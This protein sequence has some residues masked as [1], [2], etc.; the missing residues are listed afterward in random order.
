MSSRIV[1]GS[2]PIINN[3][4]WDAALKHY[5]YNSK[6]LVFNSTTYITE[7]INWD[8]KIKFRNSE[9]RLLSYLFRIEAG[10]KAT[11]SFVWHVFQFDIFVISFDGFLIGR[12][13]VLWRAQSFIFRVLKKK[14]IAMPYGG[15]CYVYENVKS[16]DI[17]QGLIDSYPMT[18]KEQKIIARRVSYWK[19]HANIILPGF[20]YA[21][22]YNAE[23][24]HGFNNIKI[25]PSILAIDIDSWRSKRPPLVKGAVVEIA[26]MPN[27]RGLKG[28]E[29]IIEV[30]EELKTEG[31]KINFNLIEKR[32]NSEVRILMQDKIHILIDQ[33]YA[34]GYGLNAIE[35]MASSCVVMA[36]LS[37][38]SYTSLFINSYLRHCPIISVNK[39][40]LKQELIK[41]IRDHARINEVGD[42]SRTYIENFHSYEYFSS[43]LNELIKTLKETKPD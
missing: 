14:V 36:N 4:Y 30:I 33:I 31:F 18:R 35:A 27:H 23:D 12:I 21:D 15:D 28:T 7:S 5:G 16:M 24:I 3:Y 26:H 40:N 43:V 38:Q 32:P 37:D 42:L 34:I 41:I 22:I 2:T 39:S 11:F 10:V 25:I 13:P 6:T 29:I 1:F 17:Q 8:I 9:K 20:M 19:K